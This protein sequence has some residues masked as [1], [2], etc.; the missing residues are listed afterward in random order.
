VTTPRGFFTVGT[1]RRPERIADRLYAGDILLD[2]FGM[3]LLVDALRGGMGLCL[4]QLCAAA[5][6]IPH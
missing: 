3:S 5:G 4:V 6:A 2:R 1:P